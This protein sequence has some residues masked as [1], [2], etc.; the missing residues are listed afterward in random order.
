MAGSLNDIAEGI[1]RHQQSGTK[2]KCLV[3]SFFLI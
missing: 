3:L 1:A 2:I